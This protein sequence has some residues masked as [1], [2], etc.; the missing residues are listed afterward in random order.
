MVS[1][2]DWGNVR[3]AGTTRVGEQTGSNGEMHL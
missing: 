1:D 2:E 3:D